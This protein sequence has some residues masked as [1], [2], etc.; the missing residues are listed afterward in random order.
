[1]KLYH[2]FIGILFLIFQSTSFSFAETPQRKL[3]VGFIGGFS[4]PGA[5]YGIP[6]KN[7]FEMAREKLPSNFEVFY[8]DDQFI[9]VKT[10]SAFRRLSEEKNIDVLIVLGSVPANTIVP[11]AE[12]KKILTFAWAGDQ[13]VALNKPHVFQTWVSGQESG[14]RLASEASKRGI[15]E[16]GLIRNEDDHPRSVWDGFKENFKGKVLED[17]VVAPG[18]Q[19]FSSILL[20]A[21]SKGIS[22]VG[23][24]V[25]P[26]QSSLIANKARELGISLSFFGCETLDDREEVKGTSALNGTWFTTVGVS[27]KF[28]EMYRAHFSDDTLMAGAAVHFDIAHLISTLASNHKEETPLRTRLLELDGYRGA[29]DKLNISCDHDRC[30]FGLPQVIKIIKNNKIEVIA[31]ESVD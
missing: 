2:V 27:K 9:P 28:E 24:C 12:K 1:M 11:F 21:K 22:N 31:G 3:R 17:S 16:V 7:G 8:E 10:T 30:H 6:C 14:A 29:N 4:G 23:I 13:N 25:G 5:M 26:G 19:D 18:E 20:K 15:T